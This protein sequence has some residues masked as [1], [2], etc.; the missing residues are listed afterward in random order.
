MLKEDVRM[1]KFIRIVLYIKKEIWMLVRLSR[2]IKESLQAV[3]EKV[4][5]WESI[6]AAKKEVKKE[7]GLAVTQL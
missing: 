7:M 4:D 5:R 6:I 1:L 2:L 3:F